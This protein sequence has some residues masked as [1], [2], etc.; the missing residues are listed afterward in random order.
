MCLF[1]LKDTMIIPVTWNNCHVS[2][3]LMKVQFLLKDAWSS[4]CCIDNSLQVSLLFFPPGLVRR[5]R[6]QLRKT[7]LWMPALPPHCFPLVWSNC[8]GLWKKWIIILLGDK[9]EDADTPPTDGQPVRAGQRVGPGR[10][11]FHGATQQRAGLDFT[12]GGEPLTEKSLNKKFKLPSNDYR[13]P[14]THMKQGK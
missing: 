5:E 4:D 2:L 12:S 11:P 8:S 6:G 14:E 10:L 1:T 9:A 13:M 7:G 3:A